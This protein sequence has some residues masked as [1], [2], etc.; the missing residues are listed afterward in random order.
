[1]EG[2]KRCIIFKYDW[3]YTYAFL[4]PL[5]CSCLHFCQDLMFENSNDN[6]KMLKYN[7]PILIYYF[8]PKIFSIFFIFIMKC[9][10]KESEDSEENKVIRRYH[11]SIIHKN[12]KKIVL[13]IYVISLLE[14][15]Y[16]SDDSI[17]SYYNKTNQIQKLI[18]KRTG[19]IISVPI[20]SYFILK[21]VPYR[22]HYFATFLSIIGSCFINSS[23]FFYETS[24]LNDWPY[25]LI[26]IMFSFFFTL[27]LVLIK[28]LLVKYIISPYT[29]LFYDGIGCM[30]NSIICII[31][32]YFIIIFLNDDYVD[33]IGENDNYWKNNFVQIVNLL[34][35]Q[36][37]KYYIGFFGS[38]I[39]SF[40]YFICNIL[41]IDIF[42]PYLNVLTDFLTPFFLY[43][44]NLC[45]GKENFNFYELIGYIIVIIGACIL[46]E[47]IILN[48]FGLN[49]NTFSNIS[50]RG[51]VD[52]FS[53]QELTT[54]SDSYDNNSE[55]ENETV[56]DTTVDKS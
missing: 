36:D 31:F 20:F 39:A 13:L 1:M 22:H 56:T 4:I 38:F 47:I 46:N 19:F 2:K 26:N 10:T 27:A 43:L 14:V 21:K 37:Y 32:E 15:I 24:S 35:G 6:Y 34:W 40:G 25:H 55:G 48:F 7:L 12:S 18:E 54:I 16:K 53:M 17:L 49:T 9:K 23:R 50:D 11:F 8:F 52:S 29:F 3:K 44:I 45:F 5:F 51:T 30:I 42:S 28:F 33:N 41:T